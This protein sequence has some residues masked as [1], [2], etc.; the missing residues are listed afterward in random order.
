MSN[1][2][3]T[4]VDLINGITIEDVI[5]NL[6]LQLN[7]ANTDITVLRAQLKAACARNDK[8]ERKNANLLKLLH[9]HQ[10][11]WNTIGWGFGLCMGG[12]DGDVT[13]LHGNAALIIEHCL[14]VAEKAKKETAN[15]IITMIRECNS[16]MSHA[17]IIEEVNELFNSTI[18]PCCGHDS[19]CAVHNAPAFEPGMCNCGKNSD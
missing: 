9:D 3:E 6:H 1:R 17:D 8:I 10:N 16:S 4:D 18:Q 14:N 15:K 5:G 13:D 12:V 2:H 19:D 11:H 7:A